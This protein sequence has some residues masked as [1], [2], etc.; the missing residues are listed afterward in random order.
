[1]LAPLLAALVS[2]AASDAPAIPL[3]AGTTIVLEKVPVR[4]ELPFEF[5]RDGKRER[6]RDGV[7]FRVAVPDPL[8]FAPR[9]LSEPFFAWGAGACDMLQSPLVGGEAIL[10]CATP[11][12]REPRVL[13]RSGPGATPETLRAA[14][15][16]R[17]S[18]RR[19]AVRVT[20]PGRGAP[21][22]KARDLPALRRAVF[23]VRA[24][25]A[26]APAERPARKKAASGR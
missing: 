26:P 11:R 13:W 10:L 4:L 1:M 19:D 24:I 14:D 6:A 17:A 15:A 7:L 20:P 21:A 23:R 9:A 16:E 22:V 2:A 3:G 5:W 18:A 8:A 25:P 12:K